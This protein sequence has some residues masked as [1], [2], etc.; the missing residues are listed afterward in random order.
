MSEVSDAQVECVLSQF[1]GPVTLLFVRQDFWR[2]FS[3]IMFPALAIASLVL[4]VSGHNS[5]GAILFPL[6]TILA[7]VRLLPS[8]RGLTLDAD[9]FQQHIFLLCLRSLWSDATKFTITPIVSPY[10][11]RNVTKMIW[12]HDQRRE[13]WRF[14]WLWKLGTPYN[15]GVAQIDGLS[16]EQLAS[17]MTQW[18]ERALARSLQQFKG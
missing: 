18:R 8:P 4:I 16:V 12:Y 1:P 3:F 2:A 10:S 7:G 6:L 14:G 13:H 5:I 15:A 11:G 9:G 17:L